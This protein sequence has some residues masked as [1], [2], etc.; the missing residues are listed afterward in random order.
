MKRSSW[1]VVPALPMAVACHGQA[2][3]QPPKPME[4]KNDFDP[5]TDWQR[6]KPNVTVYLP[7]EGEHHDGDN[8][9]FIVFKAPKSD[10]LLGMWTQAAS[11]AAATT[12]SCWPHQ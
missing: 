5:A 11:R 9:M 8:E 7:K 2:P 4:V 12:A 3:P 10:E 6:S 1:L